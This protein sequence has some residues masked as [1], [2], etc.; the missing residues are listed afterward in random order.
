MPFTTAT[1]AD[2][3]EARR[4]TFT[5]C[6]REGHSAADAD[7]MAQACI[8]RAIK[9]AERRTFDRPQHATRGIVNFLRR[10]GLLWRLLPRESTRHKEGS[11]LPV[12]DRGSRSLDPAFLAA[13]AEAMQER[14][15][16]LGAGG[17]AY[18]PV[19]LARV[20]EA[21]GVGPLAMHEAGST[22]YIHGTG[23]GYTPPASGCRGLHGTNPRP[24]AAEAPAMAADPAAYRAALAEYYAGR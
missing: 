8:L 22:P 1:E 13:R 24:T 21:A 14:V 15:A 12:A 9:A 7:D 19:A 17:R 4:I 23:E 6:I 11:P 5:A 2:W 3:T 18:A 10:R 16:D 20:Q